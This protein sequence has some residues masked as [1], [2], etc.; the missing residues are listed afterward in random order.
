L[1]ILRLKI[2][3]A[4]DRIS[5]FRR[6]E[7]EPAHP[8]GLATTITATLVADHGTGHGRVGVGEPSLGGTEG[9]GTEGGIRRGTP[10]APLY[11]IDC[12]G[13]FSEKDFEQFFKVTAFC[14]DLNQSADGVCL[15]RKSAQTLHV[16]SL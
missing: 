5:Q 4:R 11:I 6:V 14:L 1:T 3:R 8:D 10:G 7:D 15:E 2:L 13:E 12:Q 9:G 16:P